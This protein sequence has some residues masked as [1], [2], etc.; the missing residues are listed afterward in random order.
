VA[1]VYGKVWWEVERREREWQRWW[2]VYR[3]NT[4]VPTLRR[5]THLPSQCTPNYL[6]HIQHI[7]HF[8][9]KFI[10]LT[11]PFVNPNKTNSSNRDSL[12]NFFIVILFWSLKIHYISRYFKISKLV[13]VDVVWRQDREITQK[14]GTESKFYIPS[15]LLKLL[16]T[17]ALF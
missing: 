13:T 2:D 10:Q 7:I 11:F 9:L 16:T 3:F 6:L 4:N 17:L 14:T 15:H 5:P 8:H 1:F 12:L